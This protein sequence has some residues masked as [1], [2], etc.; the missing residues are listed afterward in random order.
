MRKRKHG[1]IERKQF[2]KIL[3]NTSCREDIDKYYQYISQYICQHADYARHMESDKLLLSE[4]WTRQRP[5]HNF[6]TITQNLCNQTKGGG[7]SHNKNN[8][9]WIIVDE[10]FDNTCNIA[11][12]EYLIWLRI[13]LTLHLNSH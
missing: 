12:I 11:R 10:C 5:K 13:C 4:S 6:T 2:I 1:R 7:D 8:A 9:T 3:H